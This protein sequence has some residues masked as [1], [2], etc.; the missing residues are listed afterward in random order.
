MKFYF[1]IKIKNKNKNQRNNTIGEFQ[2]LSQT[3]IIL[4]QKIYRIKKIILINIKKIQLVK[5]II[6]KYNLIK[7]KKIF[8][9]KIN[10]I[11]FFKINFLKIEIE[12]FQFKK[13]KLT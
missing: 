6:R 2:I 9:I 8:L 12:I 10:K 13:I 5:K 3:Q 7:K 1:K 11:L 4:I